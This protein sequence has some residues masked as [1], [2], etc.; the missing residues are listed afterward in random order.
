MYLVAYASSIIIV[1]ASIPTIYFIDISK[2][3][4]LNDIKLKS[5]DIAKNT[6]ID[7]RDHTT[8][9]GTDDKDYIVGNPEDDVICFEEGI[10]VIFGDSGVDAIFTD[11]GLHFS[12][13]PLQV[14][15]GVHCGILVHFPSLSYSPLGHSPF[16]SDLQVTSFCP[17]VL[18]DF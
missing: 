10:D 4:V 7:K 1:A 6:D 17:V 5:L 12:S 3:R 16:R 18:D 13:I 8:I 9:T 14:S 15:G 11:G 2:T